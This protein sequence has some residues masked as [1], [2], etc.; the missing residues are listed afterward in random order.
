MSSSMDAASQYFKDL[1]QVV[2][3]VSREEMHELWKRAKR[4]DRRA[5]KRIMEL[6]PD[7]EIVQKLKAR[8]DVRPTDLN[9]A[10]HAYLLFGG[11]LLA[12]GSPIPDPARFSRLVAE[13]FTQSL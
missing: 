3:Q 12:E 4:G 1:H 10:D 2:S 7:H 6:N 11:A 5:K 8:F 13:L 9:L